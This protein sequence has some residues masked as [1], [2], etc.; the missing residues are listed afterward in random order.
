M[1]L[2]AKVVGGL[3]NWLLD[4]HLGTASSTH[5]SL[6]F[7]CWYS[8][9]YSVRKLLKKPLLLLRLLAWP[10]HG[11]RGQANQLRQS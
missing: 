4:L 11:T 5:H 3:G 2:K 7:K 1:S 8:E 10:G 9:M 6:R